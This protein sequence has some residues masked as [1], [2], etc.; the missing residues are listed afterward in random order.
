[1]DTMQIERILKNNSNTKK[2]FKGVY[3]KDLLPT[4]EYPG[5]YVLNTD[6]SSS[7][8]E[9]WIGVHSTNVKSAEYFDSYVLHPI[10]HGLTDFLN[11]Y[12]SSWIHNSKTLQSVISQVCGHDTVYYISFRSC[13]CS[14]PEIFSHFSSNVAL[15]DRTVQRFVENL[16]T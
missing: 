9:H 12:S 16:P 10:V 1:M 11:S 15:N 5:I 13:D 7:S 6:P 2:I 8:G 14:L 4:A 3:P